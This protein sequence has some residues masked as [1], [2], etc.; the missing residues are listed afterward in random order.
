[1]L[2]DDVVKS[3]HN[4]VT[5]HSVCVIAVDNPLLF[6]WIGSQQDPTWTEEQYINEEI[7][8]SYVEVN[9]KQQLS[10]TR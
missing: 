8:V 6:T 3:I 2:T 7:G 5:Y 1:L 9:L 4:L 10:N